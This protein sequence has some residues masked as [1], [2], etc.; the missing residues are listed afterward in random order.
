[1][2]ALTACLSKHPDLLGPNL[3]AGLDDL[4]LDNPHAA[5]PHLQRA[6]RL[7]PENI[8]ARVGLGNSY[9]Q[10]KQY[11]EALDQFTQATKLNAG[12]AEAWYG[13]GATYLSIEKETE[14][15][16]HRS[17]SPFRDG[18]IGRVVSATRSTRQGDQH[19]QLRDN[20]FA[21][22]YLVPAPFLV[23]LTF[24]KPDSR[25]PSNNSTWIGTSAPAKGVCWASSA[26]RLSTRKRVT[27]RAHSGRSARLLQS[28]RR[29]LQRM[30]A[31]I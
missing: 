9:L 3:I 21:E 10:L 14:N 26:L 24:S 15:D 6:V 20:E 11:A 8:E 1:M 30:P 25:M 5:L 2:H 16:L 18:S 17:A 23:L 19:A 12:N 29:L 13:M 27:R 28:T 22:P 7:S 4:K 31:F